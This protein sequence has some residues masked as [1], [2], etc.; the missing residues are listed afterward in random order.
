MRHCVSQAPWRHSRWET[1]DAQ[2]VSAGASLH[3]GE[4][5]TNPSVFVTVSITVKKHHDQGNSYHG[6]HLIG[7]GLQFWGF[8]PLASWREAWRHAGRQCWRSQGFYIILIRR[9]PRIFPHWAEL[10]HRDCDVLPLTRSHLLQQGHTSSNKATPP[11]SAIP[12]GPS[13]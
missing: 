7:A 4:S 10:E 12:Y 3:P 8:S 6:Q 5:K 11:N 1:A 9:K 13:I 2:Q